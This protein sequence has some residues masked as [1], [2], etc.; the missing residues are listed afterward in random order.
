MRLH[1]LLR[2]ACESWDC[3]LDDLRFLTRASAAFRYPGESADRQDAAE[4][5]EICTRLRED[6][7]KLIS[8]A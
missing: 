3:S 1:E 8:E 2:G 5:L 7:L 6:L 4:A